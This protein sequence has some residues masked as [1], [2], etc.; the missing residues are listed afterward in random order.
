VR[1]PADRRSLEQIDELRIQTPAG[2]V[3][4]GI[5]SRAF[6]RSASATSTASGEETA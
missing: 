2:N 6:R 1:F 4:I 3:P 5:S